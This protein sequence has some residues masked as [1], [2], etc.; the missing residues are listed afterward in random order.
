[1][2]AKAC[3]GLARMAANGLDMMA[4]RFV[5]GVVVGDEEEATCDAIPLPT[6]LMPAPLETA[7]ARVETG[8]RKEEERCENM[9]EKTRSTRELMPFST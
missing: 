5:G 7:A 2:W 3:S 1:M 6:R 4:V 9:R 8:A